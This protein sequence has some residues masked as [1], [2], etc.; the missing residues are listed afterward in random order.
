[1]LPEGKRQS[2]AA[3]A[4]SSA[5]LQKAKAALENAKGEQKQFHC[6]YSTERE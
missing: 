6:Y 4:E 2:S 5:K 1:M 3:I